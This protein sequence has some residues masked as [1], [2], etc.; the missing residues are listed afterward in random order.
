MSEQTNYEYDLENFNSFQ[1]RK[2]FFMNL[3]FSEEEFNTL[4]ELNHFILTCQDQEIESAIAELKK[5]GFSDANVIEYIKQME[6]FPYIGEPSILKEKIDTLQALDVTINDISKS[7]KILRKSAPEIEIRTK[8]A[9]INNLPLDSFTYDGHFVNSSIVWA[10][11]CAIK[12]RLTTFT[13]IYSNYHFKKNCP[14]S[15]EELTKMYPINRNVIN[16]IH[17]LYES[18]K[19]KNPNWKSSFKAYFRHLSNPN[20]NFTPSLSDDER[21]HV[22]QNALNFA[23]NDIEFQYNLYTKASIIAALTKILDLSQEEIYEIFEQNPGLENTDLSNFYKLKGALTVDYSLT[24]V[25]LTNIF[26]A[27]PTIIQKDFEQ[28]I[29]Y[30][31]YLKE[32]LLLND[33]QIRQ[34]LVCSP[35]TLTINPLTLSSVAQNLSSCLNTSFS[36]ATY[37]VV[38]NP[39]VCQIPQK[40]LLDNINTYLTSG[41][42]NID[43]LNNL[44]CLSTDSQ[45]LMLNIMLSKIYGFPN[46][47][48]L[49]RG[50]K[51]DSQ[52]VY[53][54]MMFN[55]DNDVSLPIYRTEKQYLKN[56]K[57][58]FGD[59]C[60]TEEQLKAILE[61][62][63]PLTEDVIKDVEKLYIKNKVK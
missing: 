46:D 49:T 13:K 36:R 37:A 9:F 44:D 25:E 11:M 45:S 2:L 54:R 50:Y 24:K 28:F 41:F 31:T 62:R 8:L 61:A 5:I 4:L 22:W 39:N 59:L 20:A 1:K 40:Q 42:Y 56:L 14:Y 21:S 32:F 16:T 63:Y 34:M 48:F 58:I 19:A 35:K 12:N 26:K 51:F 30:K 6:D 15:T 55:F 38:N 43:I 10:R 47:E 3:G 23:S 17:Q 53:S 33:Y 52:T 27:K 57:R 18:E 60:R 7:F 29:A